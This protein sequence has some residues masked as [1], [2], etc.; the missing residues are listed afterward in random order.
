MTIPMGQL[1]PVERQYLYDTIQQHKPKVV[2]EFGTWQGGG[3]TLHIV[4]SI[5]ANGIGMLYSY[6]SHEPYYKI[7][8]N[9]YDN[10][11]YKDYIRLYNENMIDSAMKMDDEFVKSI[12]LMFF[13]GGDEDANG[14]YKLPRNMYPEHSENLSLF[15]ILESRISPGCHIIMHDWHNGRGSFIKW[16]LQQNSY[17]SWKIINIIDSSVGMAHIQKL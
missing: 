17:N 9:Y 2:V 4:S 12:N 1:E 14:N 7:A 8:K 16:Y 10:S 3:S 13:D 15:K 5:R 11:Q 6:E